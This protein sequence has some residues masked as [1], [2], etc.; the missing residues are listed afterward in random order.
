[1]ASRILG[2]GDVLSLIEKAEEAFDEDQAREMERKLR[3][4]RFDLS[5]YLVQ[6]QQMRK[7]GP[8]DQIISM[9][10]GL[11]NM[12]QLKDV[13]IDEK[14]LARVEAILRSMTVEERGDPSVL[15]GSRRRRIAAGSGTSVQDVNRLMNQFGQMKKM[16]RAMAGAEES[17]KR[18]RA[19]PQF[20]FVR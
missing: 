16:I 9:I 4:N 7:M 1:M 15:N 14:E 13:K 12:G 8:L 11:G 10:P 2:M 6:L 18:R 3:E 17:G 19:T 5:D 20:P